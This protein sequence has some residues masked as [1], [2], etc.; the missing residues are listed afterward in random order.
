MFPG[1]TDVRCVR[2]ANYLLHMTII[3]KYG[4]L[5]LLDSLWPV[6]SVKRWLYPPHVS[7]I[8]N[9]KP[10]SKHKVRNWLQ[11]EPAYSRPLAVWSP[12][13]DYQRSRV[14]YM[15]QFV[16]LIAVS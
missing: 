7:N 15:G 9:V 14:N 11:A 8:L 1:G 12:I 13:L 10:F 4:C 5:K 3:L 2:L 16:L 6:R